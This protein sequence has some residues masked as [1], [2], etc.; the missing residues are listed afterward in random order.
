MNTISKDK[1][2]ALVSKFIT[3]N[4][5]VESKRSKEEFSSQN[6]SKIQEKLVKTTKNLIHIGQ[7]K[8]YNSIKM[9]CIATTVKIKGK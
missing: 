6:L 2:L 4:K 1:L 7:N 9:H 3:L 5:S 8:I